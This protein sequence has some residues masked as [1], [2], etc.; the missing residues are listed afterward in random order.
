MNLTLDRI[1]PGRH[2]SGASL[3]MTIASILHTLE[4]SPIKGTDGEM[5]DEA[6]MIASGLAAYVL[7]SSLI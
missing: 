4:V 5:F 6:S 7:S 2:L 1:C 3:F